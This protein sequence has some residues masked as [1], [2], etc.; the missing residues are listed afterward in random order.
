DRTASSDLNIANLND[1]PN[2]TIRC[3]LSFGGRYVGVEDKTG[4]VRLYD[5]TTGS[6]ITVSSSVTG[7]PVWFTAPFVPPN[8]PVI[9]APANQGTFIQGQHVLASYACSDPDGGIGIAACTGSASSGSPIDTSA[10]G[11]HPFTVT[12]IEVNGLTSTT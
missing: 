2:N 5:R 6:Q 12:A 7:P 1:P 10:L 11:S 8:P 9:A 4:A 3:T